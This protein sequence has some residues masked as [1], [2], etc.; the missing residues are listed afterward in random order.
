MSRRSEF[1]KGRRKKRNYA[2]I[3]GV[4]LL[5]VFSVGIVLFY[6]TQKYAVISDDGVTVELPLLS[7]GAKSYDESGQEVREFERVNVTV[8]FEE[9]DY[10]VVK[11]TVSG[12]VPP[13]RAIFIP[14]DDITIMPIWTEMMRPRPE[15]SAGSAANTR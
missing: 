5:L 10:S 3:P 4:I 6:S 13:L 2:I 1:Y 11:Q 9:A 12:R 8:Q 7:S 14:Y 15:S